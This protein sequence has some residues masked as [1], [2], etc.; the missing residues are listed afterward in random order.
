MSKAAG[1]ATA[2]LALLATGVLVSIAFRYLRSN[3]NKKKPSLKKGAAAATAEGAPPTT[4]TDQQ[5][6][7]EDDDM[8]GIFS[9]PSNHVEVNQDYYCSCLPFRLAELAASQSY[10]A[11]HFV[12]LGIL[13]QNY[14]SP[15]PILIRVHSG[16]VNL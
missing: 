2:A 9:S 16:D 11:G 14:S 6:E 1:A 8:G 15:V 4:S 10:P 5:L 13:Y 7:K 12:S 3:N